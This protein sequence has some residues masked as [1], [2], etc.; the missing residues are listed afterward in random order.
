M[1]RVNAARAFFAALAAAVS[2]I[3]IAAGWLGSSERD[4]FAAV[5]KNGDADWYLNAL[6]GSVREVQDRDVFYHGV[7][8]SIEHARKA[9]IVILG[10]SML[11]GGMRYDQMQA[12]EKAHGVTIFNLTV[13]GVASGEFIRRVIEKWGIRPKLWIINADDR[14]GSFFKPDMDDYSGFSTSSAL[15]VVTY[16]RVVGILHAATRDVWWQTQIARRRL[17]GIEP[18]VYSWRSA[19]NGS[20]DIDSVPEYRRQAPPI[21]VNRDPNCVATDADKANAATYLSRIGGRA[22]LTLAPYDGYCANRVKELGEHLHAETILTKSAADYS[23]WDGV[24]MDRSGATA[25]TE[26]FLKALAGTQSFKAIAP[27]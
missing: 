6:V 10:H 14:G 8:R 27:Q 25:F 24:H 18:Y 1:K 20:S 13:E 17:F 19:K 26:F 2:I 7:G 12:F 22:I 3:G 15:N 21:I 16:G 5:S 11:T 23:A 4:R 9:D